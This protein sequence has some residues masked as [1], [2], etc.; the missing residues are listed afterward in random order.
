MK[1]NFIL[2][3]IIV[4]CAFAWSSTDFFTQRYSS[5]SILRGGCTAT[6]RTATRAALHYNDYQA[7]RDRK[8]LAASWSQNQGRIVP[9]R[10]NIKTTNPLKAATLLEHAKNSKS[11]ITRL[12]RPITLS[13][14]THKRIIASLHA[15]D[16]HKSLKAAETEEWAAPKG[17]A[18]SSQHPDNR[19]E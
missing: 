19:Q 6:Y 16:Y 2:L 11:A 3:A 15:S 7:S 1:K 12:E 9:S 10:I 13:P 17:Q 18:T 14:V 5:R 4:C 8:I